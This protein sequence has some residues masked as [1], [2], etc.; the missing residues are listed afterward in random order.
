MIGSRSPM[1]SPRA[2]RSKSSPPG[3]ARACKASTGRSHA[4]ANPTGPTSRG[5]PIIRLIC[6]VDDLGNGSSPRRHRWP[7]SSP[8]SSP[9]AGRLNRSAAGYDAVPTT[10]GVACMRRNHLRRHLRRHLR[11]TRRR[12]LRCDVAHR[13]DLS[14]QSGAAAGP[15][16][17]HSSKTRVTKLVRLI[18]PVAMRCNK[19]NTGGGM[20]HV[21]SKHPLPALHLTRAV[22]AG[23]YGVSVRSRCTKRCDMAGMAPP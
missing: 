19:A 22:I 18:G 10:P 3:S 20:R 4:T 17:A 16:T 2:S 9:N 7:P 12:G 23:A 14:A 5:L 6:D 15:K 8:A 21:S 11:P 13:S 1:G